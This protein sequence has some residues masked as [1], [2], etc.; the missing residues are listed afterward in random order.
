MD[1]NTMYEVKNRSSSVLV[2]SITDT[3]VRREFMP[4]E[5]KKVS[6]EELERLTY[7]SGGQALINNYLMIKN[8]EIIEDLNVRPEPEYYLTEP[9]IVDLLTNGS[10]DQFLDC[11]DFAPAGVIELVKDLSIKLPL[12]DY[13]K[14]QALKEKIGFDL[15][16]A[17]RHIEEERAEAAEANKNAID[18]AAPQRRVKPAAET[19]AS[20]RRAGGNYK[21]VSQAEPS[22]E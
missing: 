11:L 4:G 16:A 6:F 22:A 13:S 3:G 7:Q 1:K 9:Q 14:R 20:G 12:S 8:S 10:L 2:Y 15:D 17:L 21:I 19:A 5:T 18:P